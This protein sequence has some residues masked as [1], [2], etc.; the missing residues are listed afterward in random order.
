VGRRVVLA[1]RGVIE[2][3]AS[4][5]QDLKEVASRRRRRWLGCVMG[6]RVEGKSS[7]LQR[8]VN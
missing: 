2:R 3:W 6:E 1:A 4:L 5:P 8:F 7:V